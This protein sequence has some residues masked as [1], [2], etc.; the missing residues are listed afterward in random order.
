[1]LFYRYKIILFFERTANSSHNVQSRIQI[2]L[3]SRWTRT[4]WYFRIKCGK[5]NC[6]IP[7]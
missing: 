5:I 1:M 6:K 7:L 3:I 4:A 2:V